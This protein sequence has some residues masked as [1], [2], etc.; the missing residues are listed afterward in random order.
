MNLFSKI[1]NWF[2]EFSKG[3]KTM[4]LSEAHSTNK[5]IN[6]ATGIPMAGEC[7]DVEGN[8]YDTNDNQ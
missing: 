2:K 6:P 1:K 3:W 7:V 4:P 5:H 8:S